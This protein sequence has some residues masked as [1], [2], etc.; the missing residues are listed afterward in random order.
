MSFN[1]VLS[2]SLTW[3]IVFSVLIVLFICIKFLKR[4][5]KISV[6]KKRNF[7]TKNEQDCFIHL[8]KIL[9]EYHICPQVSM[10]AVI[11]PNHFKN[12]SQQT[13]LRNKVQSK[14][15][16]F[17][18][19]NS[20]METAFVIELDDNSHNNKKEQDNLRDANLFNAGITTVRFRRV[21]G[22]FPTR[23]EILDKLLR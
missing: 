14:V 1:E 10:G 22:N 8:K 6:Y 7:L 2:D 21:N 9:P 16:D 15:I 5:K 11:E 17:V 23:K 19:L 18:I 13:I 20:N 12:K 4:G 3:I